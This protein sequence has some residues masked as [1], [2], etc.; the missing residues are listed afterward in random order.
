MSNITHSPGVSIRVGDRLYL[1]DSEADCYYR[2]RE[3]TQWDTSAWVAVLFII[4]A[5]GL[6]IEFGHL[7]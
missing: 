7:I 2:Y 4:A 3:P 6:Y 1:Y 5:I